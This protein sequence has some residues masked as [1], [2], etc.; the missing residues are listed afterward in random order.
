[1]Q[2]S[3]DEHI[4]VTQIQDGHPDLKI[5]LRSK[6]QNAPELVQR[7]VPSIHQD[8]CDKKRAHLWEGTAVVLVFRDN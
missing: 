1:M 8:G 3:K 6:T 7:I 2:K 4:L 5:V